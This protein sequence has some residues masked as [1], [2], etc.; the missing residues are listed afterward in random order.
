MARKAKVMDIPSIGLLDRTQGNLVRQLT[1][2]L[3]NAVQRGDLQPGELLPSSRSLA[4]SLGIARGTVID[5]FEQLQAE[6]VLETKPASGTCV[7]SSLTHQTTTTPQ[8]VVTDAGQTLAPTARAAAF[9]K[10]YDQFLPLPAVPFAVSVPQ[11]L[12][13]P[14]ESW[15]KLGNRI[16]ARGP[17]SPSG[18][19]DPRG[20]Q[21]LREAIAEYVRR[22]RSVR[23][24][25]Q[26]VI[27][28]SGIQQALYLCCQLLLENGDRVWVEDPAYRGI[29]AI[30]ENAANAATMVRVPV[31]AEGIQVDVGI[32]QAANARAAFVTPSHQYPLGMPMS[33]A[34]RN[35]LLAWAKSE[36]AWIVEDD[37]DSELRYAG[38]PFPSL[39]GLDPSRVIYLGTFSKILFPSL[40]LGY[41]IVPPG[42]ERA[43]C[44]ARIL[45]DRH[46]PS[47]DQHVLA[48]FIQEGH[49]ERHI[50]R[51]RSVYA[52]RRAQLVTLLEHHIPASLGWL[53]PSDQG[54]HL[55]LWLARHIDDRQLA[56]S[57]LAAGVAVRPV[58]ST[59]TLGRSRP[60]LILG[61]G[62]FDAEATLAAVRTLATLII[63]APG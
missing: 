12:A 61:L 55:V 50:R 41:A 62:D 19:D 42:L 53:Q 15:R 46:P 32:A 4:R 31:D 51:I 20:A 5:A 37:Y 47:A 59:F 26:Q 38:H 57:A 17:G 60:G 10:L 8:Q 22:S 6:G 28:T 43:F 23:C 24:E 40:R 27:I 3:R 21:V 35:A 45:M 9:A 14:D 2:T 54:M 25:P 30:L 34:R 56:A 11:G 39:Q 13:L 49:L 58:S 63:A 7:S 48:A 33:M 16:R 52:E 18:Y 36:H 29:T 1:Q 44:G